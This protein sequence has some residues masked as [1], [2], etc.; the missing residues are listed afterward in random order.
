MTKISKCLGYL[1][2]FLLIWIHHSNSFAKALRVTFINPGDHVFWMDVTTFM[3]AAAEDLDIDLSV[4]YA[5]K[6]RLQ[7][8]NRIE[9][10]LQEDHPPDYLIYIFYTGNYAVDLLNK[11][12][13]R[14]VKSMII[15]TDVPKQVASIVG[16]PRDMFPS[17]IGHIVPDDISAGYNLLHRLVT[18]VRNRRGG[19][20]GE[21]IEVA[22]ITGSHDS[23]A[24]VYRNKGF[25]DYVA[26]NQDIVLRQNI[27]AY[28][29]ENRAY[30]VAKGLLRRYPNLDIIWA[31]NDGMAMGALR[32]I[33]ESR[34]A[35][36]LDVFVGGMDWTKE[37]MDKIMDRRLTT[38]FGGHFMDGGW[39]LVLL[40]DYH[41]GIDFKDSM[42]VRIQ[43][44]LS[45]IDTKNVE[46]L[47]LSLADRKWDRINFKRFSK[48]Y[49]GE[50]SPYDF[51]LERVVQELNS[52]P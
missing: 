31:A 29:D 6:N 51:S 52:Q 48:Y 34:K 46:N 36:G 38:S 15:N 43:S 23:T 20:E 16:E 2:V 5:G 40:R 4:I 14:G 44:T 49:S 45:Y 19:T 41:S 42:G 50:E 27:F 8:K 18:E 7:N 10:V 39:A 28:W 33:E 26:K 24:A 47:R 25:A 3:K 22:G 37:A 9:K 11:C 17:W 13:E 30:T 12:E 32:A 21:P 1:L 35:A